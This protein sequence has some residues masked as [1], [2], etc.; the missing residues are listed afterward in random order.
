MILFFIKI[1]R[2]YQRLVLGSKAKEKEHKQTKRKT[3]K[4]NE[5]T[6]TSQSH[7]NPSTQ[8]EPKSPDKV[9]LIK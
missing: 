8:D 5:D 3:E 7:Q 9:S 4:K 1:F 6:K 2:K